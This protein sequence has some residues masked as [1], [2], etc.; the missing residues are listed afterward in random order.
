MELALLQEEFFS[1]MLVE[2]NRS[3]RTVE[4]YGKDLRVFQRFLDEA[5][6]AAK[7]C[8]GNITAEILSRYVRYLNWEMRYQPRTVRR[9]IAALKSLFKYANQQE[10]L[11]QNPAAKLQF[12]RFL[13][14]IPTY[15]EKDQV[16]ALFETITPQ[17]PPELRDLTILKT[18]FYSGIRVLELVS[19]KREHLDMKQGYLRVERGKGEKQR[20]IPLHPELQGQLDVYLRDGPSCSGDFLFCN[21]RGDGLS[22]EYIRQLL[23]RCT[24]LAGL[25]TKVTP[26]VLRHS[27][28]TVL[29]KD[30]G[31]DL[32]RLSLLLGHSSLKDTII[33][34]HT[35]LGHLKKAIEV[36]PV[37]GKKE[38]PYYMSDEP[39]QLQ[40]FEKGCP[41]QPA[42]LPGKEEALT[43]E[44]LIA[45]YTDFQQ[46]ERKLSRTTFMSRKNTLLRL[47]VYLSE[48]VF[49]SPRIAAAD[50]T[51]GHLR[52]YLQ[53]LFR[54]RKLQHISISNTIACLKSF[55]GYA[56]GRG[57]ISKTP[58]A[59][60]VYPRLPQSRPK[61]LQWEDICRLFEAVSREDRFYWRDLAV[62]MT[63]FYTGLRLQELIKVKLDD[64]SPDLERLTVI[65]GKGDKSRVI[66]LHS[67]LQERLRDYLQNGRLFKGSP[68]LF[69][70]CTGTPLNSSSTLRIFHKSAARAGLTGKKA[71]PLIFR[72]SFATHLYQ[73]GVDLKRIALLMG[74]SK[75]DTTTRYTHTS[76]EHLREVINML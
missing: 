29:Y 32:K 1:H 66:P 62:M 50:I 40:L 12:P 73:N 26:H 49:K 58:S 10:Y 2:L 23:A 74:H 65:Y 68:Y 41:N 35:D 43:L 34:A 15:L 53:H 70:S 16:R 5:F 56:S 67:Y 60:L 33:Y 71:T 76:L 46:Y 8:I 11:R 3:P 61:Y 13:Q 36:L 28:A 75:I 51:T 72:H 37:P 19:L 27:F 55:F 22:T 48:N 30:C 69:T 39:F 14:G 24:A 42:G 18:L 54:D 4:G 38:E 20:T 47:G 57:L 44:R 52:L 21:L 9:H 59:K 17:S 7:Q 64:L 25:K 6:P 31:V 45:I 63:F